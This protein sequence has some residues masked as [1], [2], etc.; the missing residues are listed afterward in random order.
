MRFQKLDLNLLVA[1]DALLSERSVWQAA[2]RIRL[3][4]SATSSALGR[5]REYFG[6]DLL[7]V[8]GRHMVLTPRGEALI[9]PVRAVLDQIRSTI[10]IQPPFDMATCDRT[11]TIMASDYTTEVLLSGALIQ[12]A[13]SAPNMRFEISPLNDCL[14]YTLERGLVDILLT[15]DSAV[16]PTLPIESLF[17]DDYVVVGWSENAALA[18]GLTREKYFELGHVAVVF[19]KARM[20]SF[21]ESF[22]RSCSLQRRIEVVAPSFMAAPSFVVG[23]NRIATMH[24]RLAVRMARYMPLKVMNM[25]FDMPTLREV[26]QWSRASAND[27]V[28]AWVVKQLKAQATLDAPPPKARRVK[29]VKIRGRAASITPVPRRS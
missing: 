3:S 2:D 26:A 25:P 11:I 16:S 17:E 22:L 1:L 13:K 9:E 12:F 8:K 10:A 23:S 24:R 4:Q 15:I 29:L 21:E 14:V 5:L 20:L 19:G 28:I 18:D 27:E 6:D 7:A